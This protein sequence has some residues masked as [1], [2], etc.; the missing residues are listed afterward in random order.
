MKI[1]PSVQPA[2]FAYEFER[3]MGMTASAAAATSVDCDF[4]GSIRQYVGKGQVN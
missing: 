2:L 1:L 3:V 4:Q